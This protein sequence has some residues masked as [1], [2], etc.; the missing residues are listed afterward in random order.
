MKRNILLNTLIS[1]GTLLLIIFIFSFTVSFS[2]VSSVVPG[3]HVTFNSSLN[4]MIQICLFLAGSLCIFI[5]FKKKNRI[6]K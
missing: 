3:I 6:S 1:F 2:F 4:L 5:G